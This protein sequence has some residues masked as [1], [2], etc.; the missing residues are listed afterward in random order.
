[1]ENGDWRIFKERSDKRAS[2]LR[3]KHE[4]SPR[5]ADAIAEARI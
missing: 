3:A 2:A 1:M 5:K 4:K